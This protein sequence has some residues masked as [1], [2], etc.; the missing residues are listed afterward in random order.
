MPKQYL[1][2]DLIPK[3]SWFNN[4]RSVLSQE[5]WD[6]IR[7]AAYRKAGY[8]C[9]ICGGVGKQWPVE[10]HEVWEWDDTAE[11]GIQ[12]LI[13]VQALCPMCHKVKHFGRSEQYDPQF[14]AE[15]IIW[16]ANVNDW[17]FITAK[18]AVSGCFQQWQERSRKKW[19]IDYSRAPQEIQEMVKGVV[20]G[21]QGI[22]RAR[23]RD[24]EAEDAIKK[25]IGEGW[26]AFKSEWTVG[27]T[28][29]E[30]IEKGITEQKMR[31]ANMI[32][33]IL[34][35]ESIRQKREEPKPRPIRKL[36]L[37]E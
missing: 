17:N 24:P 13:G 14:R 32:K 3:T 18:A 4:L 25:T 8:R 2:P 5:E 1:I 36:R 26:V 37:E 31:D 21:R 29:W 15:R 28:T 10:C 11:P 9:E 12:S 34:G 22:I 7:K 33:K 27:A 6:I 30:E 19:L 20:D 23:I 16:I 35:G